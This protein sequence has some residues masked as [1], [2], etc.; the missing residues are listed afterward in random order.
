MQNQVRPLT[1]RSAELARASSALRAGGGV[2]LVGPAGVGKTRLARELLAGAARRGRR[3]RWIGAT[4]AAS[5]VPLGV[6][7]PLAGDSAGSGG[8]TGSG[9]AGTGPAEL[10]QLTTAAAM[11]RRDSD[12]LAVDDA[13]LLDDVSAAL[14]HH[15]AAERAAG[16]VITVRLGEPAPD[17][18][19]ALWKD[20]LL[21]RLDVSP[22]TGPDIAELL[23]SALGGPFEPAS[24]QRLFAA[25]QGNVLWLRHLVRGEHM[26]GRL[27][28]SSG[29]WRWGGEPTI[30]PA[31]AD[32]I[33]SAIGL[34][35]EPMARLLAL[36]ALGEPLE[37]DVL[38]SLVGSEAVEQAE[39]RRLAVVDTSGRRLRVR[40][41]H[42]LY[43]EAMRSRIG[44]LRARHLR[45]ELATALA[46]TGARRTGDPLR[47]AV[48]ILDSD[49][50]VDPALLT[51]CAVQAAALTDIALAV[52]M[53]RAARDAGGGFEP[54][55]GLGFTLSWMFRIEEAE[56]ELAEAVRVAATDAE[57][58]RAVLL[59]AGH[60]HFLVADPDRA[61]AA[62]ADAER[63]TAPGPSRADLDGIRS[64]LATIDGRL[65]DAVRDGRRAL[66]VPD[67]SAQAT[68]WACWGLLGALG[69]S[70]H[71]D[72]LDEL[73]AR[74]SAA[75]V[76]SPETSAYRLN[77]AY[78]LVYGLGLAG[79]LADAQRQC[80]W[81][82]EVPGLHAG[83]FRD[84]CAGRIALEGGQVHSAARLLRTVRDVMPGHGGGWTTPIE[85]G[86]A[87]AAAMA[88][89]VVGAREALHRAEQFRHPGIVF[90]EPEITLARAWLAASEGAVG[91]A[92]DEADR[93]ASQAAE[94]GQLG[95][96]VVARHTAVCFGHTGQVARLAELATTVHGPRAPAAAAH[97]S[98]LAAGDPDALLA[99][100][101]SLE[102]HGLLL[103]A[104]DATA[105][106]AALLSAR[107]ATAQA[108]F[109]T[110]RATALA[111][112]C[113][114]ARTP[115]LAVGTAPLPISARERE[116]ATLAASGLSNREVAAR[117]HVSVRTVEGHIYR[118]CTRL[119]LDD[120]AALA[121]LVADGAGLAS[122]GRPE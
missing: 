82:C 42:P 27:S 10:G 34:L 81:L 50:P 83:L 75:A 39:Q 65:D 26:A 61:H 48:L 73:G 96:E 101:A 110:A 1:G 89:D 115:A 13:H 85:A 66:A 53:F 14:L 122:G 117:L 116:V 106:A 6:F 18:V 59:W 95:V 105:Q 45:G 5:A 68:F 55:L 17:A 77:I 119:G 3:V 4:A 63:A 100:S 35:S 16:L 114:G 67:A 71:G 15:L 24:H 72:E 121:N 113:E 86:V 84:M 79:Y 25:T 57:R 7:A 112:R 54:Q 58:V 98:A 97:A 74:A 33:D 120:R 87:R 49:L 11:V 69:M 90:V 12:I 41:A 111:E 102:K 19:T 93:A 52:R 31:L 22:L 8:S 70:G 80:G 118:A 23:E 47:R 92:V 2:V 78:W 20:D 60:L 56:A 28:D 32:L 38:A 76:R 9:G 91:Q 104:A 37:V 30:T 46:A 40:L 109:A 21:E 88:G 103:P 29:V 36:L 107:G 108:S 44:S 62:L 43:G 64:V 94:R 51:R 99:V